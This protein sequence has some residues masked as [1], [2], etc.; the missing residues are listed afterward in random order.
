MPD[1]GGGRA[2]RGGGATAPLLAGGAPPPPESVNRG[3][4]ATA[5]PEDA[6][7]SRPTS[8]KYDYVKGAGR[9]RS[10]LLFAC[11]AVGEASGPSQPLAPRLAVKVRLGAGSDAHYYVLSRYLV[12]R[13]LTV[14]KVSSFPESRGSSGHSCTCLLPAPL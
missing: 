5:A 13:V 14:T 1:G 10:S 8:S 7:P 9:A 12:S 3:G 6:P 2:G 11:W 4:P